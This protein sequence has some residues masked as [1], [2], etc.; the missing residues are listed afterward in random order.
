VLYDT[1]D[2]R[3]GLSTF[4]T[5]VS[6]LVI[7]REFN[8]PN[9]NTSYILENDTLNVTANINAKSGRVYGTSFEVFKKLSPIF[10]IS[11][12]VT[13]TKGISKD[14]EDI[15]SPLDHIPPLYGSVRA[16]LEKGKWTAN[17]SYLFNGKKPV[18]LYGGTAD[19]L[20]NATVDGTPF[21][22]TFNVYSTVD[23]SRN[24]T[25]SFAIENLLDIHY[26]PFASGVSAAGRNFIISLDY[27]W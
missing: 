4:H 21:W 27:N 9:G 10:S 14:D 7:R 16:K 17:L 18:H 1:K 25:A 5:W 19:N 24:F 12:N 2:F 23:L 6:D 8:L 20:E 22:Q 15:E 13:Y 26:R 3:I 11:G